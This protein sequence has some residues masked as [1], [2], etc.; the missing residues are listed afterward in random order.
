M[1]EKKRQRETEQL[2]RSV[3]LERIRRTEEEMQKVTAQ[4]KQEEA[5][6]R[7]DMAN[8]YEL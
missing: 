5:L 3:E 7:K 6:F 1:N 2:Q 4:L 8:A